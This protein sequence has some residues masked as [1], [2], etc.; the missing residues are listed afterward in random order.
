MAWMY[1]VN[2]P[3]SDSFAGGDGAL[4]SRGNSRP[5]PNV[6]SAAAM[7]A[8]SP[9]DA[10][11]EPGFVGC[12]VEGFDGKG[13]VLEMSLRSVKPAPLFDFVSKGAT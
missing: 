12:A 1:A 3:S 6:D 2:S 13:N 8:A 11:V 10:E 4:G 5:A 7:A 9:A